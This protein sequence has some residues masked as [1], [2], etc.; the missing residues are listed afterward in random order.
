MYWLTVHLLY[1]WEMRHTLNKKRSTRVVTEW[2]E[3]AVFEPVGRVD[4]ISVI[5]LGQFWE[6]LSVEGP[7]D[8]GDLVPLVP[9]VAVAS[10]RRLGH[11]FRSLTRLL[12]R[13]SQD[14]NQAQS[15]TD[16]QEDPFQHSLGLNRSQRWSFSVP[17]RSIKILVRNHPLLLYAVLLWPRVE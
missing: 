16:H 17:Q 5:K 1:I 4:D 15:P 8:L 3:W 13:L 10:F 12:G 7:H 11:D 2:E 14:A 6:H 9:L